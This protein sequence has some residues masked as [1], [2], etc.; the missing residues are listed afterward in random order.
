MEW[1]AE[2]MEERIDQMS[3]SFMLSRHDASLVAMILILRG[4]ALTALQ[5]AVKRSESRQSYSD[6]V[7]YCRTD[8]RGCFLRRPLNSNKHSAMTI[9]FPDFVGSIVPISTPLVAFSSRN[10][11][12]TVLTES[13]RHVVVELARI[14]MTQGS[15]VVCPLQLIDV[16]LGTC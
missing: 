7:R 14:A 2:T 1:D 10:P 12:K 8:G 4:M 6:T 16:V 9:T 5:S 15:A 13:A 11:L 3:S